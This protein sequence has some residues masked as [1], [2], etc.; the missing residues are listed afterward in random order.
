LSALL[1]ELGLTV[2][3]H[4]LGEC[5]PTD[6]LHQRLTLFLGRLALLVFEPA[7]DPDR[8][9]IGADLGLGSALPDFIGIGDAI[10]AAG[11]LCAGLLDLTLGLC[12][13]RL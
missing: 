6:I 11:L 10:V 3:E 1:L 7:D 5:T 4:R 8:L 13:Y 12:D 9:N 2:N